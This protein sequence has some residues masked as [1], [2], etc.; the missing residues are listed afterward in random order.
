M[1]C[2]LLAL[3]T[4]AT[5]ASNVFAW[6]SEGHK[7]VG[8]IADVILEQNPSVRERVR[9]ILGDDSLSDVS[10]WADCAK[11]FTYCHMEPT[12]EQQAYADKNPRHHSFH[13]TD[14][15]IQ[16][17]QYRAGTAGTGA[18]DV[19][20][21]IKYAFS[22]LRGNPSSQGPAKLSQRE[23][24][25]LLA[26]LVG[27]IHQPLHV[28]AIYLDR[29]CDDIV[30]PNAVG[31]PPGFGIGSTVGSTEGGT[32]LMLN[33]SKH[34]HSYWDDDTVRGAM[35]L[36][37]IRNRSI[38]DFARAIVANPP[39]GWQT[40]GDSETWSTQWATEIMPLAN[41]A[42]SR[43]EID[44]GALV[45]GERE[46]KCTAHVTRERGYAQWANKQ[47]LNQLGKAGFRLAELIKAALGFP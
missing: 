35:R 27:D 29:E 25:W 24:L 2:L 39:S 47:A 45:E 38:E 34:L 5:T 43:V 16:Q 36:L 18:D 14:V 41:G 46:L 11:G 26:H 20:Q 19:V 17:S 12:P 32:K 30:D 13:Y 6:G 15:P 37:N 1:R 21:V 28:G 4:L 42:L 31:A 10:V 9:Q 22:V 3:L 7:T 33:S 44:E 23:A 8:K 40:S